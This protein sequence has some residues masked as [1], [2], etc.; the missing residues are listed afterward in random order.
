M[1]ERDSGAE[2]RADFLDALV[3]EWELEREIAQ[4]R[5]RKSS[6]TYPSKRR[7]I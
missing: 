4:K 6:L 7:I 3:N 2:P 5:R 1:A